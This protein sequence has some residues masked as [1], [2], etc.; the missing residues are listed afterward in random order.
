M[1]VDLNGQK[2]M[3]SGFWESL[4][5]L[6][7]N[8]RG[9]E[10]WFAATRSG[11][12]RQLY[13]TGLNGGERRVLNVAGGVSL[14]DISRE[15]RVLLS[16][17]NE[18]LGI[19]F[20]EAGASVP[21]ELSWKDF[22]IVMDISPDGK[23][24]LFGEQGEKSG[25][26]Y[27]VGLRATDGSAPV[28]LGPGMAQSLSPDN[29]WALSIIPPPDEQMVL[30]PTGAGSPRT[31][32]RGAIEH[33]QLGKAKWL[34]DGKR[35][36][37]VGREAGH[38]LRCYVQSVEGGNPQAF[39]PDGTVLCS[40]SPSG[41]ILALNDDS[42]A[43]LYNSYSSARPYKELSFNHGEFPSGWTADGKFI[44]LVQTKAPA[45]I[46]KFEVLSGRRIPWKPLE[47]P[48]AEARDLGEMVIKME[49]VAITPDG[50][51]YSYTYGRHSSDLYLVQ[52][53]K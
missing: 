15:G 47:L 5:G 48:A 20:M 50:Q 40:V 42:R 23:R 52:G 30:L 45:T 25:P 6:A 32:E 33:Y 49:A 34:P 3:L 21:R 31:L 11:L 7:W 2:K 26:S 22:S 28:I 38:G 1:M 35:I 9:D 10:V 43:L 46:T 24:I 16:R 41:E 4:R 8:P 14:Q 53:L 19:L 51:S 36:L 37:F 39:T 27:Q 13:A 29:K 12:A 18:R 17:D 44:Y